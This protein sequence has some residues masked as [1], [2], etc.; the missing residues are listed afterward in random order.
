[1][2]QPLARKEPPMTT[3]YAQHRHPARSLHA[4]HVSEAMHRGVVTCPPQTPLR[5]LA[6]LLAA[7]RIHSVVV[8][9]GAEAG[10]PRI[11]SDLDLVAAAADGAIDGLTVGEI[12]SEPS[13]FVLPDESLARAA[14]LM[15]EYETH[16]VIV[17]G[18]HSDIPVGVVSTLDVAD[19][20]AELP[21]APVAADGAP[22]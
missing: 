8:A 7:H 10:R 3:T 5:T 9:G 11:V 14:Q 20:V 13:V 18:R 17:L 22:S 2:I 4:I 12:A 15:R 1:M 16:H 21:P 19:A 6:R